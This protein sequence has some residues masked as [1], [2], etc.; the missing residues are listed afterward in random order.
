MSIYVE[1]LTRRFGPSGPPA[2]DNVTFEAPRGVITSLLG[3]SGAG[4]STVLRI[5]A[6]LEPPDSGRVLIDGQDVTT[7]PIQY[8]KVGFVFQN[9]ALFDHMNVRRNVAFGLTVRRVPAAEVADRVSDLLRRV[10][11]AD[12]ADRYPSQ[13]S[14]GQRQRVAFARALAVRPRVLL[15]DEPFGA[16]DSR[17]RKEM[18]EWLL[19]LHGEM[20]VTTLLVTHDQEEALEV[21]EHIVVMDGGRV[22][23]AGSPHEVY[24]EP[25]DPFTA[26]FLGG[27]NVIRGRVQNGALEVGP[28]SFHVPKDA[29]EGASVCVMVRPHEVR[30]SRG[31]E[32]GAAG[33]LKSV[34]RVGRHVKATVALAGGTTLHVEVPRA[35]FESMCVGEG[36]PVFL[37]VRE[38]RILEG[39]G[40]EYQI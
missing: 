5:V 21:S 25:A 7:V 18:R 24:D 36:D 11:L 30:L 13:L 27:A 28:I 1:G 9:Y 31:P 32:A 20:P 40:L 17:V 22:R 3:P 33:V 29:P 8:R 23:Q 12:L 16:L 4:K 34:R 6:G 26:E 10:Q 2:V 39:D 35:E 19:R 15:L 14:G 37:R 38:A